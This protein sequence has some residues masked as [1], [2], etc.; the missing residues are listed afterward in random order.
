M[1]KEHE[2]PFELASYG[3]V[4]A[5]RPMR[6]NGVL[7][8]LGADEAGHRVPVIKVEAWQPADPDQEAFA[9]HVV[10]VLNA[11]PFTGGTP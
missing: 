9:A 11:N 10:A 2:G 6:L 5:K 3:D 4:E 8:I 1:S 7:I